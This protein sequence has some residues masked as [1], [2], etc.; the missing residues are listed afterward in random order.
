MRLNITAIVVTAISIIM[1]S[2]S[3]LLLDVP[4]TSSIPELQVLPEQSGDYF[5]METTVENSIIAIAECHMSEDQDTGKKTYHKSYSQYDDELITLRNNNNQIFTVEWDTSSGGDMAMSFGGSC[6]SGTVGRVW[7]ADN[8]YSVSILALSESGG[9]DILLA[10]SDNIEDMPEVTKFESWQRWAMLIFATGIGFIGLMT[11]TYLSQQIKKFD[12]NKFTRS[13]T[14]FLTRGKDKK[15]LKYSQMLKMN[16][17]EIAKSRGINPM[18]LKREIIDQLLENDKQ[19]ARDNAAANK[20]VIKI[21]ETTTTRPKW[22]DKSWIME[23]KSI[24]TWNENNLYAPDLDDKIMKE[25]PENIGSP[26]PPMFTNSSLLIAL[27]IITFSWLASDLIGRHHGGAAFAFGMILRIISVGVSSIWLF[28]SFWRW[29]ILHSVIDTPTQL[30]RSAAVGGAEICGQIRPSNDNTISLKLGHRTVDGLVAHYWIEEKKTTYRDKNGRIQEAWTRSDSGKGHVNSF[31]VHDGTAGIKIDSSAWFSKYG[32]VLVIEKPK[33]WHSV[34]LG[35][36]AVLG[37]WI[38]SGLAFE[39][40]DNQTLRTICFVISG[41]IVFYLILKHFSQI[42][43]PIWKFYKKIKN[44]KMLIDF[45]D[46][47]DTWRSGDTMYTLWALGAGEPV[48]IIGEIGTR[49]FEDMAKENLTG[50]IQ[51]EHLIVRPRERVES[52]ILRR[53]TEIS[54]LTQVR[55]TTETIILPCLALIAAIVPFFWT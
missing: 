3:F 54:L 55:S 6:H 19:M 21:S 20:N 1:G 7:N 35:F 10:A 46:Y 8:G 45:G 39:L 48:Y 32:N 30:I 53:G 2:Y 27:S 23:P 50:D 14:N 44:P 4:E 43:E 40:F 13:K 47:L 26:N 36:S 34:L 17:T 38:A 25:H 37:F 5:K 22:D 9:P 12:N 52:S 41:L 33:I 11:P 31:I 29:L 28:I 18:R 51:S 16:L 49:T 42:G 24:D 15:A